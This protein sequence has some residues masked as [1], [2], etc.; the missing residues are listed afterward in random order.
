VPTRLIDRV[1][2]GELGVRRS[3]Q[4]YDHRLKHGWG[5]PMQTS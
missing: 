1:G 3:I 2:N 4:G 5:A